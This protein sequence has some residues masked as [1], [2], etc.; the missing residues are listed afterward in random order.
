MDVDEILLGFYLCKYMFIFK[1]KKC[2]FFDFFKFGLLDLWWINVILIF[3][4]F[5]LSIFVVLNLL[6]FDN[7]N[8]G[9]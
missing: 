6:F 5:F 1:G 9:V 7:W 4:L 2:N 3:V 8:V